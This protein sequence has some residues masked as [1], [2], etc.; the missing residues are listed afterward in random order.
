ML[1][2]A[3]EIVLLIT[4]MSRRVVR[5]PLHCKLEE[6]GNSNVRRYGRCSSDGYDLKRDF[7][8]ELVISN[9]DVREVLSSPYRI[10]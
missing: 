5:I 6:V 9:L 3:G 1:L 10:V 7:V 4:E 8:M 2:D